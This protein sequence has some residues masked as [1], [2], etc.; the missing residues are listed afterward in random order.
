MVDHG[1]SQQVIDEI[2]DRLINDNEFR[3]QVLGDPI[4]AFKP[5]GIVIDP[6]NV[7]LVRKLPSRDELVKARA[8]HADTLRGQAYMILFILK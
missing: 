4:A 3:E 2:L 1:P 6:Q 5:Y 8:Q 7:P